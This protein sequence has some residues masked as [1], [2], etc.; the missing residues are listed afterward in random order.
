VVDVP[1]MNQPSVTIMARSPGIDGGTERAAFL[2][3]AALKRQ[4]MDV[5]ILLV[6]NENNRDEA[7][8]TRD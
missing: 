8:A 3:C 7:A 5:Q 1:E 4:A 6:A 2:L